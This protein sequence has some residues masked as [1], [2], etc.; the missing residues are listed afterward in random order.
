MA[1]L[2]ITLNLYLEDKYEKLT[3]SWWQGKKAWK[4]IE[5]GSG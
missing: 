5:R 1:E 2:Q 3:K 4:R